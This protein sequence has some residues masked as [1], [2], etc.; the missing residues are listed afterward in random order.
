M[1]TRGPKPTPTVLAL[2]KGDAGKRGKKKTTEAKPPASMPTAPAHLGKDAKREWRRL[3]RRLFEVGLMTDIDRGPLAAY[4]DAYG[5]WV[6]ASRMVKAIREREAGKGA[7]AREGAGLLD[8]TS[9][10]N[11]ILHPLAG[12]VRTARADM[13]RY[14]AEFGMTPSARSRIDVQIGNPDPAS[15]PKKGAAAGGEDYFE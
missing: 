5:Q 4:C 6:E 7:A 1:T 8:W 11:T 12:I 2:V 10:G 3:V 9:N 13:V 14:A 15:N